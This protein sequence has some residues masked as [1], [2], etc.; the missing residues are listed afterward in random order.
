MKHIFKK[1]I[2]VYLLLGMTFIHAGVFAQGIAVSGTITDP[3]GETLPGVNVVIKG[4]MI[5]TVSDANG[6]YSISVPNSDAI[7]VFTSIGFA[8]QEIIV[9]S[10]TNINVTMQ[11]DTNLFD[12]LVVVG[13]GVQRKVT[14]TGAVSTMRGEELK[15]S[16][17]TNLSN[18]IVGRMPGVIGFQRNDEPGGG[19]TTIRVR[20]TST[21]GFKDPLYV[22]DGVPDREGGFD[23]L[24]PGDI[25]SI[26]VLKDASAAIYGSRAA[27]GVVLITT[28]RGTEGKPLISY[29]GGIGFTQPTRIPEMC[30]SFEYATLVNEIDV[31][32]KGVAGRYTDEMLQKF[33]DGSDPWRYPNTNYMKAIKPVSPTYRHEI[34]VSGGTDRVKYFTNL[35]FV[36]EEGIFK[37][38]N[39]P[40]G[41]NFGVANRFDNYGL[42][43]NLDVKINDYISLSYGLSSRMEVRN[44]PSWGADD[45]FTSLVRSKPTD[46]GFWPNGYPGPDLEYGHQPMVMATKVTGLDRQH[47]Y[48]LSNDIRST[49]KVPGVDGLTVVSTFSYDKRFHNRKLLRTP[50]TLYQ[51]TG[52]DDHIMT[53]VTRGG[54]SG[55]VIDLDQRF[56]DRTN[57]LVNTVVNYNFTVASVH[58]FGIMGGIEG[59]ARTHQYMRAYRKNFLAAEPAEIDNGPLEER[60]N[61]GNSWKEERLNYFGRATYNFQEKYLIEFIGRYDGSWRFPKDKR[62]GFFPGVSAAWRV[63][64]ENFW[65]TSAINFFKLRG[66][67]SQTGIDVLVD[68]D[69]NVDRTVQYLSTYS[70]GTDY[71]LGSTFNRTLRPSRLANPD[72]TWEKQTEYNIGIEMRFLKNRLS[73]ETDVYL[74]QRKNMLRYRNATLPLS[75]GFTLPRENIGEMSNRG[76]EL[77]LRWDDRKGDVNYYIAYNMTYSKDRLDYIDEVKGLPKYQVETGKISG[78]ELWYLVD[79]VFQ[80]NEEIKSKVAMDGAAPGDLIFRDVNNDGKIDGEDRVRL[81]KRKEP[82]F[83]GGVLLGADWKGFDVKAFIQGATGGHTYV[84]RERAGESGNF[85]KWMYDERWTGDGSTNK[86]PRIYN[87][88]EPY[89]ARMGNTHFL[90]STDYIRLKNFEIGYSFHRLPFLQDL[91]VQTLRIF[92]QGSNLFTIDKVK[93]QDPEQNDASKNYMQRRYYNF[94]VTLTF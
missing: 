39:S 58:N 62:Y 43:T 20:G 74:R 63:S 51:W 9:G 3:S 56:E 72:I 86:Y 55:Y 24:N 21:Q 22:I 4:T 54:G 30:N 45:I 75:A 46:I 2:Y 35:S 88:E 80:N 92:A 37:G 33:K 16:P 77:L 13:Y 79:G 70:F 57:W 40:D 29:S 15:A 32:Y 59:Q 71:L 69:G 48:I 1:L 6:R 67:V 25:E 78:T 53:P 85:F 90:R 87:R 18:G 50:F 23:R 17:T 12:E 34:G 94:G 60:E 66:S 11:D 14:V 28:R 81:N 65:N 31:Y 83:I 7:L 82:L 19:G 89:W 52:T 8:S 44:F 38:Y 36:G 76:I 73:L 10:S 49:I 64:E 26:S 47:T 68:N 84:Y 91:N 5:G 61:N 27:N 93:F 41:Q 42:R